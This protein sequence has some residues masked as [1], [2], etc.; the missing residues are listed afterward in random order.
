MEQKTEYCFVTDKLGKQL[1]PTKVSK[2]WYL[3][4]KGRA[5]LKSKYPMVIQLEKV[6]ESDDDES[7]I[8]CGIDDG[9]SHSS[10]ILG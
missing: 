9:S 2:A 6:I 4:R 3:I 10:S 8:V 7:R 1:A 5:T